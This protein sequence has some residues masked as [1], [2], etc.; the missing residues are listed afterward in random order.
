MVGLKKKKD[1]IIKSSND[2]T[3][4]NKAKSKV[5]VEAHN[6]VRGS[7]NLGDFLNKSY[8][9]AE[10]KRVEKLINYLVNHFVKI[11]ENATNFSLVDD[12]D[13]CIYYDR[14]K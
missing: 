9:K 2:N 3:K 10:D 11:K 8:D 7:D 13:S 5:V 1:E 6:V 4:D 14:N 12:Y